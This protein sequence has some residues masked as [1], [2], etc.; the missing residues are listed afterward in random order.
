MRRLITLAATM[1]AVLIPAASTATASGVSPPRAPAPSCPEYIDPTASLP[2]GS[3]GLVLV[4]GDGKYCGP[5]AWNKAVQEY[6]L[7]AG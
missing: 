2:A 4:V 6:Q 7:V 5:Y 3:P 1:A